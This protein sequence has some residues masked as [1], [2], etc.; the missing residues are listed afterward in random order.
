MSYAA[1]KMMHCAT[2]I[3]NCAAGYI[4]HSPS[5]FPQ[6]PPPL[7][8]DLNADLPVS[9]PIG[10]VPNLVVSAGNVLEVYAVRIEDDDGKSSRRGGVL[11]DVAGARLELV[12]HYR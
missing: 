10:P 1:F 12:C 4:T 7:L 3:E 9:R 11:D 2:G 6:I 5:D 8:D